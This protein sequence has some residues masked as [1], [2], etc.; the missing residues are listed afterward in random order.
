MRKD[1]LDYFLDSLGVLFR[2]R[3][4]FPPGQI[5]VVQAA[6]H[7]AQR[8][9]DWGKPVRITLLGED[10]IADDRRLETIPPSFKA[11]FQSLSVSRCETIHIETDAEPHDL[12]AWIDHIVSKSPGSFRSPKIVTGALKLEK[13]SASPSPLSQAVTGYLGFVF[14]TQEALS[15]LEGKKTEGLLR[16][17]EIVC[18]IASRLVMGRE[19][20]EPIH[21]LKDFDDYTFTHALNVCVLSSALARALQLPEETVNAISL[22]ALC[23][24]LGK[25]QIPREILNKPGPLNPDERRCIEEHPVYGA[26][27]LIETP[28]IEWETPLLPVVAYQ[29]H[30]GANHSGYPDRPAGLGSRRPHL[31]S[32][33]VAVAD[34]Y[35]ALRTIRPYRPALT[36]ARA[37]SILVEEAISGKLDKHCVSSFLV[38][39]K[40]LVPGRHIGLSDGSRGVILETHQAAPLV[41]I[42]ER[43]DGTVYDLSASAAVW[44]SNVAEEMM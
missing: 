17:K 34:V 22:A 25:R 35:D 27:V 8:L 37:S 2:T 3:R 9:Q 16:A 33:I 6:R 28:G 19:I 30:A 12:I 41:P 23:H 44:I 39:L 10:I 43:E 13:R 7:A 18:S 24:D 20:F 40:V 42:V 38:L 14:Q 21:E 11:L 29:H 1:R 31:A 4:I 26:R 5:Q 32:L 15:D 36:I